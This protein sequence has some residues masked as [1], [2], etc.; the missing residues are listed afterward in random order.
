MAEIGQHAA[1]GRAVGGIDFPPASSAEGRAVGI[2]VTASDT[3]FHSPNLEI[4]PVRL[5][6]WWLRF[7]GISSPCG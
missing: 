6:I 3:V 7:I 5:E 2:P 1:L 4:A